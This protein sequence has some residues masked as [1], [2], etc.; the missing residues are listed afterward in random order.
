MNKIAKIGELWKNKTT[1]TVCLILSF[2][3]TPWGN[4][5][6]IMILKA[7]GTVSYYHTHIVRWNSKTFLPNWEKL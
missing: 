4:D 5:I 2:I 1:M 6:E 3:K 7:G